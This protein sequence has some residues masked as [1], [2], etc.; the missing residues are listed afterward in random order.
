MGFI[1]SLLS[2]LSVFQGSLKVI[3][4]GFF[5]KPTSLGTLN[6]LLSLP[7]GK[8]ALVPPQTDFQQR[9]KVPSPNL[10]VPAIVLRVDSFQGP[11]QEGYGRH[12]VGE[13]LL[14]LTL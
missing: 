9:D 6:K 1:L 12:G 14:L 5:L 13:A 7:N 4:K 11:A 2:S 3:H 8:I 10:V